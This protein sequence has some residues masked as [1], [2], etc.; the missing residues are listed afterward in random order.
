LADGFGS[1]S[2]AGSRVGTGDGASGD[3][4]AFLD[5][6]VADAAV[7]DRVAARLERHGVAVR[8]ASH[9]L[10][11]ERQVPDLI[12]FSVPADHRL[13]VFHG[14]AVVDIDSLLPFYR[15]VL[16]FAVVSGVTSGCI[17]RTNR[18][19]AVGDM[20]RSAAARRVRTGGNAE[21]RVAGRATFFFSPPLAGL[22]REVD[23]GSE[24]DGAMS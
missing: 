9:A 21:L 7:L 17:C 19:P 23:Q 10:A 15:D 14:P 2:I 16:G 11:D 20:R 8:R 18:A 12:V 5:G 24:R 1:P 4:L 3:G 22:S 6:E 13:D